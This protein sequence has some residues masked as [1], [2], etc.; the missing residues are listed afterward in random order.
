MRPRRARA[1]A[2][3]RST[4]A[5][6]PTSQATA[7]PPTSAAAARDRLGIDVGQRHL[8]ALPRQMAGDRAADAARRPGDDDAPVCLAVRPWADR[9]QNSATSEA[10]ASDR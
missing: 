5:S 6:L 2:T 10:G 3:S 8:P 1:T 7:T 9:D 4:S